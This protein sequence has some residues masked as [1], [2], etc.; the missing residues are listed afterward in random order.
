MGARALKAEQRGRRT[1]TTLD[2][3][4]WADVESLCPAE[5]EQT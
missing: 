1:L 2:C 5:R 4:L 3:L